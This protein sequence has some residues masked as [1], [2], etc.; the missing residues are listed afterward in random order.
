MLDID[1]IELRRLDLT[2]LLVFL[3]LLR[4]RKAS[5]VAGHMGLTQSSISHS[6]KRLR[7]VFGDPL[8]LRHPRG[9]EPT[10]VA[11]GLEPKIRLAVEALSGAVSQPV[12]F[13]PGTEAGTVRIGAYDYEMTTLV[14]GLLHAVKAQAPGLRVAIRPLGRREAL[15]ALEENEIDI[16]LG[17]IWALPAAFA[18]TDLYEEGYA[19]VYRAGHP[20]AGEDL[21]PEAYAAAVHLVVSPAGEF[22]GIVDQELAKLGLARDVAVVVPLFLPAL[23]TVAETDLIA[24]LPARL[25]RGQAARFGL[26]ARPAPIPIRPFTVSAIRHERNARN[27]MHDWLVGHLAEAAKRQIPDAG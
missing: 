21:S 2:V 25:V 26:L 18:K 12:A 22:S 13:D 6:I 4:L 20:L 19:V 23:A 14:P 15:S 3:N 1:E 8:F 27:P 10:A 11:L 9:M 16:A 7:D 5:D 17:F 24:T